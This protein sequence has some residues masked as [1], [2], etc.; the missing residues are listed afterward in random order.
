[1][2]MTAV[3]SEHFTKD[4]RVYYYNRTTKQSSWEK[5]ADFDGESTKAN[6][7]DGDK[8]A[9]A[10]TS[11]GEWEELWDP[12]NE[13]HYY[14]NRTSRKTQWQKPEGVKIKPYVAPVATAKKEKTKSE[15][16]SSV[17]SG[18]TSSAETEASEKGNNKEERANGAQEAREQLKAS[19][20]AGV[21]KETVE[22]AEM[23]ADKSAESQHTPAK[24]TVTTESHAKQTPQHVTST[25]SGS[26]GR[27]ALELDDEDAG[28]D[29]GDDLAEGDASAHKKRKKKVKK[30]KV[31][32]DTALRKR[33]RNENE[34]RMIICD[35]E[36]DAA[37]DTIQEYDTEDGKEASRLLKEMA[38]TDAI[39]E[40]NVLNLIN[41]F[42]RTHS[43][44]NGPEILVEKLSSSY[45]GHAQMVGLVASWLDALP[46]SKTALEHKIAFDVADDAV[47]ESKGASWDPASDILYAHLQE[48]VTQHYE[49]KLVS[50]VLSE[51]TAE[52]EWLTEML[53]D[54]KW[55]R[56]LIELAEKHKT[57]NLLQ[58]A[59]RRI[60][61]A[62]HHKEIAATAN[63]NAFFSVF[64]GILLDA[65]CR[66]PF[67]SDEEAREDLSALKKICCQSAYSYV[68]AEE[69]LCTFD[70]K[71]YL[72]QKDASDQSSHRAHYRTVR[73]KLSRVRFELQETAIEKFGAKIEVFH[74]LRRRH[75]YDANSRL[76]EAI[77]SIVKT[78]KCSEVAAEALAKEYSS[79]STAPPASH[80]RDP[81]VFRS[82]L[83]PLFNPS[84]PLSSTFSEHCVL[85]LAFAACAKDERSIL[86][87]TSGVQL[88][89]LDSQELEK[90]KTALQEASTICRSDHTLSYNMNLTGV[91]EKL[92]AVMEVPL[93]SM[94]V[95]H[96][97]EVTCTSPA[98]FNSS[99]LHICFPSLLR[100]LKAS[101]KLHVAQ[102]PI[103]FQVLVT[104]LRLHPDVN[105]VKALE[106]KRESLRTMV[107]MI[108]SGYVLPVLEFIF[109]NTPELDQALLRNFIAVLFAQIAPP[110]SAKFVMALTKILTH[111]K[112]QNAVKS[113]PPE[114]KSKLRS[115]VS[116]CKKNA[117][118][119]SSDQLQALVIA[120]EGL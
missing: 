19:E 113:C 99:L 97:L 85:L 63:A 93:A 56:M 115:F 29:D 2:T 81:L 32:I 36:D 22:K 45:R 120:H 91:V 37:R 38:K 49:P 35:D 65:F 84:E 96:W 9:A 16:K 98:F 72:L 80:L 78:K 13:R 89:S 26:H 73:S 18:T 88:V 82:L 119:L 100:I 104:S 30:E 68:Y 31:D 105:P 48:V 58:Y 57:C 43:D 47:I 112:I 55:R 76:S 14:Y 71:L 66:I 111:P 54:R 67:A 69:L 11:A 46:V 10:T 34:K 70:N 92:T 51:S 83:D 102:W 101:I 6:A 62:G 15:T 94:G 103:A 87:S 40:T 12:K 79:P 7:S 61:E 117:G 95:L 21:E 24:K 77:L 41:G 110:Y 108:T 52:P 116:Y 118:V 8:K 107:F 106:L 27:K 3:W 17:E 1:M 44:S 5:P 64:N 114:C 28:D 53:G 4:G 23:V 90:T 42:L 33:R 60:S 86:Q 109:I 75:L 25:A 59:I 39:M 20:S 50:N 74:P